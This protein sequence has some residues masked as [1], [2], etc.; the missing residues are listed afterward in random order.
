MQIR[1]IV[2]LVVM[3][4]GSATLAPAGDWP[5]YRGPSFDGTTPEAIRK[6]WPASGPKV[7]WKV[8]L[9]KSFG[10]FAVAEG[11]AC[12]FQEKP[13]GQESCV[14]YNARSG[15]LLWS[16]P[17]DK[18]IHENEGGDGPRSTPTIDGDRVYVYSTNLKLVSLTATSGAVAWSHDVASE[19]G[20]KQLH[21]GNAASPIVEGNLVI[22]AGGGAGQTFLAF[23][24]KTGQLAWKSGEDRITHA[25]PVPGTIAGMRQIVFFMQ[26]GLVAL[27]P[28][29][30]ETLWKQSFP[31]AVS[32]AASPVIG[33]DVVY[34]SAGYGVG[35]GAYKIEKDGDHFTSKELW[36]TPGSH[37]SHW[38]TPVY[39]D[40]FLYGL[41]GFKQF[42]TEPLK[43]VE[44]Q[45]G[46]EV[47]SQDGFGQG[48]LVI[49]DDNLL[50]QGDQGQLVL[51]KATPDAYTEL[52]RAHPLAGKCWTMPVVADGKVYCRSDREGMCLDVSTK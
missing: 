27:K 8:P 36:R 22:V 28:E 16:A 14:A 12:V 19:F 2:C 40:G 31:Y 44:L 52:A 5:Q 49:V 33:G 51:I 29:T 17:I 34:C 13:V 21:W 7:I 3:I 42:K 9:G 15:G 10:S 1:S 24:K 20:G 25:T 41:F 35:G 37:M 46:K 50:V 38:T 26:S 6:S 4:A 48:G 43:C 30:G 11:K 32:T 23:D 45:T 39:H 47:W 18:T